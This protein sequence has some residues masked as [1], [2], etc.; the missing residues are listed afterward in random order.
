MTAKT[1]ATT[2]GRAGEGEDPPAAPAASGTDADAAS[3]QGEL[4]TAAKRPAS[5]PKGKGKGKAAAEAKQEDAESAAP[6]R[7]PK[8]PK[9]ALTTPMMTVS[10]K[11]KSSDYSSS[12]MRPM[13]WGLAPKDTFSPLMFI[14]AEMAK[15]TQKRA[16]GRGK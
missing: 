2:F 3:V 10:L 6:S 16:R 13:L 4:S 7:E 15:M 5:S 9:K 8:K 11:G 12:R 14:R 1:T